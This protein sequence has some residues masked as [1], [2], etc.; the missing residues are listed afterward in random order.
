MDD[1]SIQ[2]LVREIRSV[3]PMLRKRGKAR[4]RPETKGS[5]STAPKPSVYLINRYC[6]KGYGGRD[7]ET[8]TNKVKLSA[9]D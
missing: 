8:F 4:R 2:A 6:Q 1:K 7:R 3:K 9:K 5:A